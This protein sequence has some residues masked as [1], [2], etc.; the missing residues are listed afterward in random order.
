MRPVEVIIEDIRS[1]GGRVTAQRVAVLRDVAGRRDHPTGEQVHAGLRD[2]VPGLSLTTVYSTLNHL[3]RQGEIRRF[4][5]GDGSL[6][7]DAQADPHT[8][9]VCL[10]CGR[11]EDGPTGADPL[12]SEVLGYAVVSRTE[13]LHGIC[14][15]CRSGGAESRDLA[16]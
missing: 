16:R 8:E 1:R 6:H 14:P 4:E 12:P 15:S 5:T 13:L 3:V 10:R 11:V 7:Y 9:L 2:R